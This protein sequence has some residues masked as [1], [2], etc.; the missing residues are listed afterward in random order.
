MKS[1]INQL[2]PLFLKI[3]F[4][5]RKI[6]QSD[7]LVLQPT[8]QPFAIRPLN[9]LITDS[10]AL[11]TFKP[12]EDKTMSNLNLASL[13]AI[14]GGIS[15]IS[16]GVVTVVSNGVQLLTIL[17]SA[18]VKV[19]DQFSSLSGTGATKKEIVMGTL[20]VAAEVLGESWE[21]IKAYFSALVDSIISVYNQAKLVLSQ[22]LVG[23]VQTILVDAAPELTPVIE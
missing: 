10:M 9:V 7:Q 20:A 18:V 23:P 13:S 14:L 6:G 22:V 2:I 21:S 1:A 19:E 15:S 16:S 11:T 4:K 8:I 12:K 17:K 5:N 3:I